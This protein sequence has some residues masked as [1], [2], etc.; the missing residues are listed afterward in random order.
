M[1]GLSC[2]FSPPSSGHTNCTPHGRR[3]DTKLLPGPGSARKAVQNGEHCRW[4]HC[5]EKYRKDECH[6][7]PLWPPAP[8]PAPHS[9]PKRCATSVFFAELTA[10]GSSGLGRLNFMT[11]R[12]DLLLQA[13]GQQASAGPCAAGPSQA[14]QSYCPTYL[15]INTEPVKVRWLC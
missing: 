2:S 1:R 14:P 8:P 11:L 7:C 4:P 9:V 3:C 6:I 13:H 15:Q 12:Q 5:K 10:A